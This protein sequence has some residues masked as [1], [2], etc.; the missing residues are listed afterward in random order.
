MRKHAVRWVENGERVGG[1]INK[2]INVESSSL[3]IHSVYLQF[4][5]LLSRLMIAFFE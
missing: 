2:L 5:N 1:V 4:L 3:T